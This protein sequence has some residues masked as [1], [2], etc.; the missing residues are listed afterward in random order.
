MPKA[1]HLFHPLWLAALLLAAL[2]FL[3]GCGGEF[4]GGLGDWDPGELGACPVQGDS[5][6]ENNA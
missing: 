5:P 1:R 6:L 3:G 4:W 2:L